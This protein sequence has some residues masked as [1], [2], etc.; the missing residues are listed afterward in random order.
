MFVIGRT[1]I[2]ISSRKPSAH[3]VVANVT[4]LGVVLATVGVTGLANPA[5]TPTKKADLT[6]P[7]R[8]CFSSLWSYLNSSADEC[9][10]T[11]AGITLYGTLD[12]G[13]GYEYSWR[14][15]ESE[16]RQSQLRDSEEQ[17]QYALALVAQRT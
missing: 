13:Y 7:L 12:G 15:L 3:E 1:R 9:P 4:R 10:L 6:P 5:D 8:D 17:R 2:S 14:P 11:Y 16:R